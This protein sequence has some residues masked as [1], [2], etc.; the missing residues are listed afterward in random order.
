MV[1]GVDEMFGGSSQD[2]A[3]CLGSTPLFI[4]HFHGHLEGVLNN[5]ILR[6]QQQSP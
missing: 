3:Q 4:S 2:L 6:G 5:P 1:I